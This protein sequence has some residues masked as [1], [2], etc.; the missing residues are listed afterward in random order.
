VLHEERRTTNGE[1]FWCNDEP[2]A[3]AIAE[4]ARNGC[5]HAVRRLAR[6]EAD[7][8]IGRPGA[9]VDERVLDEPFRI[10]G[11][12]GGLDDRQKIRAKK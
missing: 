12:D 1:R 10:D 9:V 3:D 5:S 4:Q 8:A 6:G 11:T 7:A 2:V